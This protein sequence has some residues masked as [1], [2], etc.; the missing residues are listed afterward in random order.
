M[1]RRRRREGKLRPGVSVTFDD[2]GTQHEH[3]FTVTKMLRED[4]AKKQHLDQVMLE[5]RESLRKLRANN[6]LNAVIKKTELEAAEA[7]A[8]LTPKQILDSVAKEVSSQTGKAWVYLDVAKPSDT[9]HQLLKYK[10]AFEKRGQYTVGTQRLLR[11]IEKNTSTKS[12][13]LNDSEQD[14]LDRSSS[15]AN[16]Q[17]PKRTYRNKASLVVKKTFDNA[18]TE[19]NEVQG[20]NS[21][22]LVRKT[23]AS[24][25]KFR[26]A[27]KSVMKS[28]S[29]E[30]GQLQSEK[31]EYSPKPPSERSPGRRYPVGRK[32]R[33][34]TIGGKSKG[35]KG[36]ESLMRLIATSNLIRR[37]VSCGQTLDSSRKASLNLVDGLRDN[38]ACD[39]KLNKH[40]WSIHKRN[41]GRDPRGNRANPIGLSSKKKRGKTRRRGGSFLMLPNSHNE[42]EQHKCPLPE[43]KRHWLTIQAGPSS[44][45]A[46]IQTERLQRTEAAR[47]SKT[48]VQG[49]ASGKHAAAAQMIRLRAWKKMIT[50]LRFSQGRK[51]VFNHERVRSQVEKTVSETDSLLKKWQN[52][53][54]NLDINYAERLKNALL[55][56]DLHRKEM[57]T[58]DHIGYIL[59]KIENASG[60]R[61]P[62]GSEVE[63]CRKLKSFLEDGQF[64]TEQIVHD[65]LLILDENVLQTNTRLKALAQ[66]LRRAAEDVGMNN[67]LSL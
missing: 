58:G 17:L 47:K 46:A 18:R 56:R 57:N 41:S 27:V 42:I 66:L 60:K 67:M 2:D 51:F 14:Y 43:T 13:N 1:R 12:D 4:V 59:S 20:R 19:R 55:V 9:S 5:F 25:K 65:L 52:G 11:K 10:K 53:F 29:H 45:A 62:N 35:K 26:S 6:Y 48:G 32:F 24:R 50:K 28:L 63:M 30:K 34:H 16:N 39:L 21:T 64:M 33:R 37:N 44:R 40:V 54:Q 36:D 38:I 7:A 3:I 61:K 22:A 49:L 31:A 8:D 15:G 23:H